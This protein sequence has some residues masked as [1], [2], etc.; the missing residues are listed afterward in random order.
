MEAFCVFFFWIWCC[1][2]SL[3]TESKLTHCPA[4]YSILVFTK[5]WMCTIGVHGKGNCNMPASTTR[6]GSQRSFSPNR[7]NT[8]QQDWPMYAPRW[9]INKL[10]RPRAARV[11]G[12]L[13][14]RVTVQVAS[15]H[16]KVTMKDVGKP[17]P[18]CFCCDCHDFRSIRLALRQTAEVRGVKPG[19]L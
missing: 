9:S 5:H 17:L 18:S 19:A 7:L 13:C 1:F 16:S 12:Q 8:A 6:K 3:F 2:L 4:A 11:D 10:Q 15:N 14:Q